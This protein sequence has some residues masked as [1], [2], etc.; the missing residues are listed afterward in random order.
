[1]IAPAPM[2]VSAVSAVAR[3]ALPSVRIVEVC[4]WKEERFSLT[5]LIRLIGEL[6]GGLDPVPD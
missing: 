4:L 1:M 2:P 5:S 3:Y 6:A